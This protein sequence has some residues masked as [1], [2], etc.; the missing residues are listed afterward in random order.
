M[1]R[2]VARRR[3]RAG[4]QALTRSAGRQECATYHTVLSANQA[5]AGSCTLRDG[6]SADTYFN[7]TD[8]E[9]VELWTSGNG[10]RSVQQ[11]TNSS[12]AVTASVRW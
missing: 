12:A 1:Q 5:A 2:Q 11:Y 4:A 10:A 9:E 8:L 7:G 3:R 6:D